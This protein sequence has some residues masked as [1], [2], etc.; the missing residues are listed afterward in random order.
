MGVS[1]RSLRHREKPVQYCPQGPRASQ[2]CTPGLSSPVRA[3]G[4]MKNL[5]DGLT[6]LWNNTLAFFHPSSEKACEEVTYLPIAARDERRQWRMQRES[7]QKCPF[8]KLFKCQGDN[9]HVRC[10][11]GFE[12]DYGVN[13]AAGSDSITLL[14]RFWLGT[15]PSARLVCP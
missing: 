14:Q 11:G 13:Y 4:W 9:D 2:H 6:Q 1:L 5:P 8:A 3:S 10:Q 15:G 12:V 7:L